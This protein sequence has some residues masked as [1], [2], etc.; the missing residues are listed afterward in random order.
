[1]VRR[2][3]LSLAQWLG[4]PLLLAV[5]CLA[6]L[7]VFGERSAV[8][9]GSSAELV[10][11]VDYPSR[12]RLGVHGALTVEVTN[13]GA[14]AL[15]GAEVAFSRSYLDAFREVALEPAVLELR[16]DWTVVGL[17]PLL[18]GD[19]G[20]VS[21]RLRGESYGKRRGV[22]EVAGGGG[23]ASAVRLELETFTFP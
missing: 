5:P 4:L 18:P 1:M 16:R 11:R 14:R 2:L 15:A 7:S 23:S 17:P 6:L 19:V 21:V 10:V 20:V 3:R 13:R 22:V 8:V 12:L 9:E